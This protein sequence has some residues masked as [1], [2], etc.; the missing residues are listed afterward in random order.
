M[1]KKLLESRN[2]YNMMLLFCLAVLSLSTAAKATPEHT[3]TTRQGCVTC[4]VSEEDGTLN[5]VGL[6][7]LLSGYQWPPEGE[8]VAILDL[9]RGK[10]LVGFLHLLASIAWFGTIIYVHLILKP[11]YALRGLPKSEVRL[12]ISSIVVIGITGVLLTLS[13]INDPQVLLETNWGIL[14]TVKMS[15]YL[16]LALAALF[17]VRFLGPRLKP[18]QVEQNLDEGR[19]TPAS[20]RKYDGKEGRRAYIARMGKVYDATDSA[21]WKDGEHFKHLA[22]EDLTDSLAHAPHGEEM[23][24]RLDEIGELREEE[25]PGMTPHQKIFYFMA[26]LNL[27]VVFVVICVIALWRWGI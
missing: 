27:A 11:A 2:H 9:G 20:L 15:L 18:K 6:A 23:L 22:G 8:S 3:E 25:T 17:V 26:Y 24:E 19:F 1:S 21:R 10:A 4:H 5:D 13:R 14:L 12:G 16:F 7:Y